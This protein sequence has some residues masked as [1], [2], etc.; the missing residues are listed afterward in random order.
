[1]I[2]VKR[3][4]FIYED[5]CNKEN[6]RE[7]ILKSSLGK[8]HQ[9]RVAAILNNMDYYIEEIRNMLLEY[10]YEPSPYVV[11]KI[12]DGANKKERVIHKPNYYPDQIIHWA[13]M[14]QIQPIIMRG[15]YEYSC[16]SIP[17]R[18][19]SYG[20]KAIKQWLRTDP[21]NTKYCLKLDIKKF[22]PSID[23]S[24]LKS[25]FRQKIKDNRCLWLIDKIIDSSKGLPIGNYTSQWFSNFFLEGLDHYIKEKLGIKYYVRYVDDLVI[26]GANKRK[27]HKTMDKITEYLT[28][29]NLKPKENWQ[30]FKVNNRP[31]DFLGL[32]FYRNRITLRKR[33]ALRIMRRMRKISRKKTLNLKDACAVISY[34]GWVLRSNS[35]KFYHKHIRP[36]ASI[37]KAKRTVSRY[38]KAN[39]LR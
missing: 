26:L 6:I 25:M 37:R 30:V 12:M 8:R 22:Y 17:K 27:L 32:K 21:K 4:G 33:T 2:P 14:L 18:G 20:Q 16:G 35:Y 11:K 38:A 31:I 19:T 29:L 24:I 13:L 1:V 28:A 7:A 39:S 23:N 34:W 10:R 9:K 36:V 15:M 3:K 5:I